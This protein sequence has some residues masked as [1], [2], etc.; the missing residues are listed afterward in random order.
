M[1][2]KTLTN[3]KS[4]REKSRTVATYHCQG[5]L[6]R[7]KSCHFHKANLKRTLDGE[8]RFSYILKS[9]SENKTFLRLALWKWQKSTAIWQRLSNSLASI[10]DHNSNIRNMSVSAVSSFLKLV[11]EQIRKLFWGKRFFHLFQIF[12]TLNQ[13]WIQTS[14]SN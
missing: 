9:G 10:N 3:F 12:A 5:R 7:Q 6:R 13:R 2:T 4:N 8:T 14:P 1:T 11:M